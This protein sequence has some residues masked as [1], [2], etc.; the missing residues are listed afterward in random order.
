[1]L[2]TP[3]IR[4]YSFTVT[5]LGDNVAVSS[6]NPTGGDNQQETAEPLELDP[7]WVVGFVDGEGCF[8]AALRRNP[9]IRSTGNWQLQPLFQVSQHRAHRA[10][11]EAMVSFFGCGA[12]RAKGPMSSVLVY[13]VHGLADLTGCIIPFFERYSL[14]VKA[15][16]FRA[17][18]AIVR[19]LARKEHLTTTGFERLVRLAYG[20]NANGKQRKRTLDEVLAGSSETVR[21]ASATRAMRQSDL[22]GDMQSEPEMS[23]PVT[24]KSGE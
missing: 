16:D 24:G 23:S 5:P 18:A 7:H 1:M 11:L 13:D 22:H 2:E 3:C 10:V 19:G 12:V 20:M 9:F 21:Q 6:D 4:R 15:D 8:C 14:L 17:F